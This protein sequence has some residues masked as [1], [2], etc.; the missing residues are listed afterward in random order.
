M[1]PEPREGQPAPPDPA[2]PNL[3]ST[4]TAALTVEVDTD[5][6]GVRGTLS[7]QRAAEHMPQPH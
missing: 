7:R 6:D 5:G 3:I 2:A 4:S 1:R